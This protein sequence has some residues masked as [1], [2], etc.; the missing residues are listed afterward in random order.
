M[1]RTIARKRFGQ[2]FLR[3]GQVIERILAV[4]AA[5]PEDNVIEIGPGDG[6]LTQPLLKRI[7]HLHAIEL[8]RDLIE[9]L[10]AQCANERR[11]KIHQADA[12]TYDYC[13]LREGNK[14]VRII[15]NLPYNIST[16]LLFHL[17]EQGSCIEDMLFMLQKE[18]V[19]RMAAGPGGRTYGRLSVMVQWRC[20]V[21]RLFDIPAEAF[22]PPPKVK[23][24]MVRLIPYPEPRPPVNDSARFAHLVM[25]AFN[26]RR[27]TLRNSLKGLISERA[28][29][30]I[31]ID[32][33]TRPER[34][35]I[36]DFAALTEAADS[37]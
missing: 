35:S 15:G 37:D 29:T 19:D 5:K 7:G 1:T 13:A 3:D 27:K 9:T 36:K 6:A 28:M 25:K 26:Q 34:L 10:T 16:P 32:P 30:A 33:Q 31:G 14:A 20:Q 24:S 18:V 11:L 2:H 21:E 4:F 17:L 22:R 23:S 8:D 12:L